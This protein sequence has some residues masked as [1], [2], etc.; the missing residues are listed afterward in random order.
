MA[1]ATLAT[2]AKI[3]VVPQRRKRVNDLGVSKWGERRETGEGERGL[4]DM[5]PNFYLFVPLHN[6]L[7]SLH[8]IRTGRATRATHA[9]EATKDGQSGQRI[10]DNRKST[11]H[12]T[13]T[14]TRTTSAKTSIRQ[15]VCGLEWEVCY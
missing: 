10:G 9:T 5:L 15:K 8:G 7:G 12:E 6:G 11:M 2:A 3:F 1:K 13:A 4:T 14:T